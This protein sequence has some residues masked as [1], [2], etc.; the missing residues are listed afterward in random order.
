MDDANA[1]FFNHPEYGRPGQE[2]KLPNH[3]LIEF[4]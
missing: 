4:D 1:D 3:M 2:V